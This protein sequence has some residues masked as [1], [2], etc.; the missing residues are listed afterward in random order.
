MQ[1]PSHTS[2]RCNKPQHQDLRCSKQKITINFYFSGL[3]FSWEAAQNIASMSSRPAGAA[4]TRNIKKGEQ[5][6]RTV[7]AV[8]FHLRGC[9]AVLS[10]ELASAVPIVRAYVL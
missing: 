4:R 6:R 7:S 9:S 2:I 1:I 8:G 10:V 3:Y 5:K